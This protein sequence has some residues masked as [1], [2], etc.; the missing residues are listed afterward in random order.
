MLYKQFGNTDKR[1]SAVGFGGMRFLAEEYKKD[2]GICAE[3]VLDAHR[4]GINYFDTAPGYCDDQ[5]ETIMGEAF[6]R[7]KYGEFHVSTKCG[8]WNETTADGVRRMIDRQLKKLNVPKITFYLMWCVK[9]LDEYRRMTEKGGI[10]EGILQAKNEGLVEHIGISTHA[11]GDDIAEIVREGRIEGV[12]L[13][14]NAINFAYRRKGIE[15][16]G[17]AGVGVIVMNPLGGGII[18]SNPAHF[19]FLANGGDKLS[20]AALKFLVAHKEIS[21][22]LPGISTA[23]ELDDVLPAT[24]NLPAVDG[25]YLDNLAKKL[26]AEMDTLCTGCNY[27]DECPMGI[28]IS[29]Y[30]DCYNNAVLQNGDMKRTMAKLRYHWGITADAIEK[31]NSCGKCEALCTQKLPVV[32]RLGEILRNKQ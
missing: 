11:Q 10:Y 29:K 31:C 3:L 15:A 12:M 26:S 19:G 14:Y 1:V 2:V 7:M 20:V 6:K 9:R 21:S 24:V 25:A 30:L 22:A 18:P 4:R 27:C 5:S 32:Q 8:L 17:E 28:E 13:G 16:C 23:A